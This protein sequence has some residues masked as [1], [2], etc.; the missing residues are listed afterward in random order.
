MLVGVGKGKMDSLESLLPDRGIDVSIDVENLDRAEAISQLLGKA[1]THRQLQVLEL[2]YGLNGKPSM[3][4]ADIARVLGLSRER[5]RQIREQC[6][7][8]I[9]KNPRLR[10]TF[11]SML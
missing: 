7:R 5:I 6:F 4:A 10:E 9:R 2:S 3:T 11:R 1:L 8:I